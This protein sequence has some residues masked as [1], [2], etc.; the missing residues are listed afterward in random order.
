MEQFLTN[1]LRHVA[2]KIQTLNLASFGPSKVS[3]MSQQS[4][5][6][7]IFANAGLNH[8]SER[9]C[10]FLSP[11]S[12]Q[13]LTLTSK[14][15]MAYSA[16]NFQTWFLKCQK[17]K[18]FTDEGAIKWNTFV[19]FAKEHEMEWNL[20]I[21]FKFLHYNGI[22]DSFNIFHE[23][24]QD[25][26][27]VVSFLG[28]IN[29]M[30]LI[31]ENNW[32]KGSSCINLLPGNI[33]S[34]KGKEYFINCI[35][36]SISIQGNIPKTGTFKAFEGILKLYLK[37][38]VKII[39]KLYL[40]AKECRSAEILII[41]AVCLNQPDSLGQTRMHN[42]AYRGNDKETIEVVKFAASIC[43]N[44]NRQDFFGMTPMHI[45][46]EHGYLELVKALL[47]NWNNK[48]A[49]SRNHEYK[50]AYRIAIDNGHQEIMKLM[51]SSW[52]SQE[53]S[54]KDQERT[55]NSVFYK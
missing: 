36:R 34:S 51:K 54:T 49:R 52:E 47:P 24:K 20:G 22:S 18:F 42:L 16:D 39:E 6:E 43:E 33:V 7:E 55:E 14:F 9:I 5:M 2:E 46:A 25:P 38:D 28:Q 12:F 45:A 26:F 21:I 41:L 8:I 29:L 23:L 53:C 3:T 19:T 37:S 30:K 15:M 10:Y 32:R 44:L 13:S 40:V 17:A 35:T 48:F 11:K 50:T 27:K 31:L 1:P 4:K